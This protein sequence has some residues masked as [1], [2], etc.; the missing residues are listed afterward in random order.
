[1]SGAGDIN[2]D[3]FD[4]VILGAVRAGVGSTE[5]G[6]AYVVFGGAQVGQSGFV[7]LALLDGSNGFELNGINDGEYAGYAVSEA[8]DLNADGYG[9]IVI[10]AHRALQNSGRS[11]V[12]YGHPTVGAGGII[13]FAS[14]DGSIGT[15][16]NGFEPGQL[17]GLS[18]SFAGDVNGDQFQDIILGGFRTDAPGL[19]NAG[20]AFILFGAAT[21]PPTC[22]GDINNDG[23]TN[24]A[25]F[26][27]LAGNFGASVTPNTSGDLNS[28]GLVNAADFVIL[29]G[30]FGCGTP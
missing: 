26:V 4:D 13:N 2:G 28:D 18:V 8:R 20:A 23:D 19:S 21:T 7:D 12:V 5:A 22:A 30:D 25:D 16:F 17:S 6:K 15:T 29:A 24:A 11:Y 9:D 1:V 27:I 3:G 10:G 14:L